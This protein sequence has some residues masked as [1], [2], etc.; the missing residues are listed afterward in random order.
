MLDYVVQVRSVVDNVV[1][2]RFVEDSVRQARSMVARRTVA[3]EMLSLL[4]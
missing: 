3:R 4:S 1:L 2:V